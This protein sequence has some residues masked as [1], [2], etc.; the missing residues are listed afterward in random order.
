MNERIDK[1]I[2]AYLK[3]KGL[4]YPGAFGAEEVTLFLLRAPDPKK[5]E[6][7]NLLGKENVEGAINIVEDF[8]GIGEGD[9]WAAMHKR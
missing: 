8:L 6:F 2:K 3:K 5:D 7:I 1:I 4:V 9:L